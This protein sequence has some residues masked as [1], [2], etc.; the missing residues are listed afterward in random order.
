MDEKI[1]MSLLPFNVE[2]LYLVP[3][4][5]MP[6]LGTLIYILFPKNINIHPT[7]LKNFIYVHNYGLHMFSG[8]IAYN[9]LVW[10]WKVG[11]NVN[12]N[13]YFTYSEIDTLVY[14]FYLSKYY[15]YFDTFILYAKKEILFFYKN[16]II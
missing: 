1:T 11:F 9:L 12:G 2:S 7:V 8:Y 10:F 6:L 16:F 3:L 14:Y 5:L 15:E 4:H 13:F